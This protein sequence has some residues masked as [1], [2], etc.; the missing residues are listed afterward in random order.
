M[1]KFMLRGILS[2]LALQMLNN[3]RRLS[4]QLL[5]IG[6]A[7]SYLRGVRTAKS[8]TCILMRIGL[9]IGLIFV[10]ALLF[11]AGLF[12]LLPWTTQMKALFGVLLGLGYMSIGGVV[13]H[14]YMG[15]R[16]WIEASGAA[17]LIASATVSSAATGADDS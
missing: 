3:S 12:I 14:R 9:L 11:H 15:E 5:K 7:K 10:G 13:L 4:V 8:A 2:A 17:E 6:V 16:W 1:L